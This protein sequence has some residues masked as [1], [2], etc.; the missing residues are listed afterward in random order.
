MSFAR[1][2]LALAM[3][4]LVAIPGCTY[5]CGCVA[6][7]LTAQAAVPIAA[8]PPPTPIPAPPPAPRAALPELPTPPGA[9]NVP[10]PSGTPGNLKVL[11]WAGFKSA[12]SYTFDD[13]QPS[14]IEHYD[15]LAATGVRMTFFV[16]SSAASWE[17]GFVSTF[18]RAARDGHE[19]GNHTVHHC[20]ADPDG[21]LYTGNGAARAAC[22][23]PSA[24]AEFDDCTAF[25]TEK[26]G[27]PHV[28]SAAWPFGDAGYA[29][30]AAWRFFLSRGASPGTVAPNDE[31]DPFKLPIWGPA[32]HDGVEKFNAEI[33]RAHA[34]DRWVI[35]LLHSLAPTTAA[36]YATVDLSAVTGSIAHAKSLGDV[37]IDSLVDVGAYW[38]GQKLVAA[39]TPALS[40]TAQA[41]TSTWTWT[42]PDHFPAGR[43]LRVRVDGGTLSQNGKALDW[44]GH[45]YYEV[46]LDAGSLTLSP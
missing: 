9:A 37:W 39:L 4:A 20:H 1:T 30:A 31:T 2:A 24:A 8:A 42:L 6:P 45:G 46:A 44:D 41:R 40:G 25:I 23:G 35:M 38:R 34:T 28:W 32:E 10:R 18:S 33:D 16:N 27:V 22:A 12:V 14:Q 13:G 26:L 7:A 5:N 17:Q 19:I 11:D 3:V 36:W 29:A 15:E 43:H 21:T